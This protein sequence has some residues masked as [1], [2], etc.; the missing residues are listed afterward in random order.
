MLKQWFEIGYPY[1]LRKSH[2][3]DLTKEILDSMNGNFQK[4]KALYESR[5]GEVPGRPVFLGHPVTGKPIELPLGWAT[6][7][8]M[9]GLSFEAYLEDVSG[10]IEKWSK[11]DLWKQS[12]LSMGIDQLDDG[13]YYLD[14]IAVLIPEDPAVPAMNPQTQ[15]GVL[16]YMKEVGI[17]AF[18]KF[19][20]RLR[21][22]SKKYNLEK[23]EESL[24]QLAE[25]TKDPST[26]ERCFAIL[27]D[28]NWEIQSIIFDK[29]KFTK[30]EAKK[31]LKDHDYTSGKVDEPEDGNTLR[32]RQRDP[33][34]YDKFRT[35]EITDGVK[36]IYGK[37]KEGK[38]KLKDMKSDE[39]KHAFCLED[40][41][42]T[43]QSI[44][45]VTVPKSMLTQD[46]ANDWI[47]GHFGDFKSTL[48]DDYNY[49]FNFTEDNKENPY[50]GSCI[51][52]FYKPLESTN[53]EKEV[54]IP[55]EKDL[56]LANKK[57][58][59]AETKAT[60]LEK[61]NA[62]KDKRIADL[63]R[64]E[65]ARTNAE[66]V[67]KLKVENRI[68]PAQEQP[69]TALLSEASTRKELSKDGKSLDA[70]IKEYASSYPPINLTKEVVPGGEPTTTTAGGIKKEH[71]EAANDIKSI[72]E[73]KNKDGGGK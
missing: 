14:H 73:L 55:M 15:P 18:E 57:A 7:V 70:M 65:I 24:F 30:E 39:E 27:A 28:S 31:W 23:I 54:S 64:N 62:A 21:S 10:L 58:Q 46:Q 41:I 36:A 19:S 2:D 22:L 8:K 72:W 12:K 67:S 66:F 20:P 25:N 35:I 69:L 43:V 29:D 47:K 11:M 38:S 71:V 33:E 37:L 63:E 56:E 34:D 3:L 40:V 42:K 60:N 16:E 45:S 4:E 52:V 59:D 9:D 53:K 6:K 50:G 32:F 26:R 5:G 51:T 13:S 48:S 61:E 49:I 44:L 1:D 68:M 17:Y